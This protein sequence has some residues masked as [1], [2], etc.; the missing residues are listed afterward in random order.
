MDGLREQPDSKPLIGGTK[1]GP[2]YPGPFSRLSDNS[3][4]AGRRNERTQRLAVQAIVIAR[5]A[6]MIAGLLAQKDR[7][8]V[9][10]NIEAHIG[11]VIKI[12]LRPYGLTLE[13][14]HPPVCDIDVKTLA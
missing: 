14:A 5:D 6:E 11:A 2:G 9:P 13:H 8:V 4:N 3:R 12:V 7:I 10:A 1:K